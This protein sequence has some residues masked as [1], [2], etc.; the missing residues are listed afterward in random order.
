MLQSKINSLNAQIESRSADIPELDALRTQLANIE[1]Q[2]KDLQLLI[3]TVDTMRDSVNSELNT[4]T[5]TVTG[6]IDLT[7]ITYDSY[8]TIKGNAPDP[9]KI[10][11]YVFSLRDTGKFEL[12]QLSSMSEVSYNQWNFIITLNETE[13]SQ[14]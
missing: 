14:E 10:I 7:T 13:K 1:K 5:S 11:N 4:I 3:A 12:V 2:Q 9:Y 6:N 8:W